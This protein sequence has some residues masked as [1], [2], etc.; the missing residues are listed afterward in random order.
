MIPIRHARP[1]RAPT[2]ATAAGG[3][4]DA[5]RSLV[6]LW[7][8]LRRL[9]RS[10]TCLVLVAAGLANLAGGLLFGLG[11][12]T[13]TTRVVLDVVYANFA[14]VAWA[15]AIYVGGAIPAR[16]GRQLAAKAVAVIVTV[17]VA[18]L[19]AGS[20][21][22]V[23]Q[24]AR[25]QA[26]IQWAVYGHGL[27]F[28]LGWNACHLA[29]LAVCFH[30]AVSRRWIAA[31]ATCVTYVAVNLAFDHDLLR[32]GAPIDP[33][34]DIGGYG[35]NFGPHLALGIHW[36]GL[37]V[38]LLAGAHLL[39]ATSIEEVR[40]R[41]TPAVA[42]WGWGGVVIWLVSGAWMLSRPPTVAVDGVAPA[43]GPQPVYSR[44]DL[45]VEIHPEDGW[46]RS[47][48]STIVR[49]PHDVPIAELH[50]ASPSQLK[51]ESMSL[52]GELLPPPAGSP[53]RGYRLNRPLEPQETL[54]V[55]FDLRSLPGVR[56]PGVVPNGTVLRTADVM[57]SLGST[58]PATFFATAPAAAFRVRLG[59]SLDQ[60]A[61]APGLLAREWKENGSRYFEYRTPT[62]IRPLVTFHSARFAR[63]R[64]LSGDVPIELYHHP[65]HA[66]ATAGMFA[67]G[68]ARLAALRGVGYPHRQL[69]IVE[70]PDWR[71]AM[72]PPG[73]LGFHWR[74][75][76][77]EPGERPILGGVLAYSELAALATDLK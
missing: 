19:L 47:R 36:T 56:F 5:T 60:I 20:I 69:R 62:P 49:N 15:L 27:V 43:G 1:C 52:T 58:D 11:D 14:M 57:P 77:G 54:K 38:A 24:L 32:F 66:S 65:A 45:N 4:S 50:V 71:H 73:L 10:R 41:F 67:Y 9:C 12:L 44:L 31:T 61:V 22:V 76:F 16:S 63:A 13:P 74:R 59:T 40:R 26:D 42:A 6:E 33:W 23:Y 17:L 18:F 53:V 3:A 35:A 48:G 37:C 75:S 21:A 72:R 68:H 30:R 64:D 34:S 28:N 70:V 55:D 39:G 51:V 2:D 8:A 29:I 46:V 25:G 7:T